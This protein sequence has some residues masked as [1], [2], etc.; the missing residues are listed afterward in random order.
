MILYERVVLRPREA[1]TK[2]CTILADLRPTGR[3]FAISLSNLAD[4]RTSLAKVL[5]LSTGNG[6]RKVRTKD[7][8]AQNLQGLSQIFGSVENVTSLSKI[9]SAKRSGFEAEISGF[10]RY[11]FV[12]MEVTS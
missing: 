12:G 8:L 4:L 3:I 6:L 10:R 7:F 1:P 5:R 2:V 11:L 9:H